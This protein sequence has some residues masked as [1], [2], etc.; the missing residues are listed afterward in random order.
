MALYLTDIEVW[1]MGR[2]LMFGSIRALEKEKDRLGH[3]KAN[4]RHL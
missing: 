1:I 3:L 4:L 2:I